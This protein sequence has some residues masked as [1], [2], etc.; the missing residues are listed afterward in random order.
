MTLVDWTPPQ[1]A[2]Q[3]ARGITPKSRRVWEVETKPHI[4]IQLKRMFPSLGDQSGVLRVSHTDEM[5]RNLAWFLLRYPMEVR[6]ADKLFGGSE[7]HKEREHRVSKLVMNATSTVAT[8]AKWNPEFPLRGYQEVAGEVTDIRG[9]LLL[10]D[11]TGV[12]KTASAI[13]VMV[14]EHKLTAVVV[15]LTHLPKQWAEQIAMFTGMGLTTHIINKG[16]PYDLTKRRG[17]GKKPATPALM[18]DVIIMSY[19]KLAGWAETLAEFA[20]LVVFDEVQELRHDES[21]RWNGARTLASACTHRLGM[22]ATPF[23]NYGGEFYNVAEIVAPGELGTRDE[24]YAAWCVGG[25]D[26]IRIK[27]P[28]AFNAYLKESGLMLRR[29]RKD[30]GRELPPTSKIPH[31]IDIDEA[32][33]EKMSADCA[34]LA[35]NILKVG[36]S[37]RGQKMQVSGEFDMKLRQATGI[38]KAPYVAEFA[39]MILESEKSVV[40]FA[41]HREVYRI[42]REK[43]AEFN[44]VMYTGSESSAEK[45][46]AKMMFCTGKSRVFL[47]SLRAGAGL[48]GLQFHTRTVI[49]GELDWSPG[50]IKQNIER[51]DRDGQPDPVMAYYMLSESGA[52]PFMA[53]ALGVK[54]QQIEGVRDGV[55]NFIEELQNDGGH[56]RRMAESYLK[57]KGSK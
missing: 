41:W 32:V 17:R 38:A 8:M 56:I 7:A 47:I 26:K 1:T 22:S 52:D 48:D 18:P 28:V 57:S 2:K 55:A 14:K 4:S 13:G 37:Y 15:T 53:N 45:D 33:F 10:C 16:Q 20:K 30:V 24:F 46:Y 25:G 3:W 27:D 54:S 43:L 40:I 19:S 35:K 21:D 31:V 9:S 36:E 5:C 50:V 34:E 23:Y 11:D 29:T 49:I 12:G 39:K 44:P 51:V 42:Y 6:P